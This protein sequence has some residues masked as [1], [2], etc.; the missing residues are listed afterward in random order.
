MPDRKPPSWSNRPSLMWAIGVGLLCSSILALLEGAAVFAMLR[1][2]STDSWLFTVGRTLPPWLLFGALGPVFAWLARRYS[3]ERHNLASSIAVHT[4]AGALVATAHLAAFSLTYVVLREGASFNRIF[5]VSFRYLFLFELLTYWAIIGIYLTVH[6]SNLRRSLAEARL[7]ALRTQLN[8]HF[9]F[10]TLHAISTMS[11]RGEHKEVAEMLGRLSDLLRAALDGRSQE[12]P[13]AAE[14]D[15]IDH[16]MALQRIRYGDRLHIEKDIAA[17][18]LGGL[19][20]TMILQPLVENAIKYGV[21]AQRGV[22][23]V[24]IRAAIERATLIIEVEDAGPGFD[25]TSIRFG[26]GL[27]NTQ[28]RLDQLYGSNHRF[29]VGRSAMGGAM[30]RV[31]VPF[32]APALAGAGAAASTRAPIDERGAGFNIRPQ[33]GAL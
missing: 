10:N 13:L 26:I 12:V 18:T 19:V 25:P 23:T 29:E 33:A 3:F 2:N 31:V 20:P 15:F 27:S 21:S 17:D 11:L 4:I 6:L 9:L 30:V 8:P 16:Y 1:G 22:G 24:R 14:L 5:G 7:M 28:G 32:R